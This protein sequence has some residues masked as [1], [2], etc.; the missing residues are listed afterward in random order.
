MNTYHIIDSALRTIALPM[1]FHPVMAGL[2]NPVQDSLFAWTR[3]M[4]G[5]K[6]RILPGP[7]FD[8]HVFEPQQGA[9]DSILYFHGGAFFCKHSPY[10]RKLAGLYALETGCRLYLPDYRTCLYPGPYLDAMTAWKRVTTDGGIPR[11]FA[12]DSA[13]A[14][15]CR[16]S[17]PRAGTCL[18][19][20]QPGR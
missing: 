19:C 11:G 14:A 7:P 20:I 13:G 18:F 1:P 6:L 10:H 12:G 3:N 4:S 17:Q 16:S 2:G 15:A 8:I 9:K 5:V